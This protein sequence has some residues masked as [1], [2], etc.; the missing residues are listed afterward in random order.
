MREA[1]RK[2]LNKTV[3]VVVGHHVSKLRTDPFPIFEDEGQFV[4]TEFDRTNLLRWNGEPVAKQNHDACFIVVGNRK[5]SMVLHQMERLDANGNA[6][7]PKEYKEDPFRQVIDE[8]VEQHCES[9]VN[10]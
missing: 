1:G 6:V 10:D 5:V 7:G 4:L 9:R 2:K 8:K 3:K